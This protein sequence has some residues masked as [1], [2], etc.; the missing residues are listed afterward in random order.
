[1]PTKNG[2]RR[3]ILDA[4]EI[5]F[6]EKGYFNASVDRIAER[7][8]VA[9][10]TVYYNFAGKGAVFLA[11]VDRGLTELTRRVRLEAE[12]EGSARERLSRVFRAHAEMLFEYPR[13]AEIL[14]REMTSGLEPDVLDGIRAMRSAYLESLVGLVLDGRHE[15]VLAPTHPRLAAIAVTELS[16]AVCAELIATG[17]TRD[18][19]VEFLVHVF[20][21][22][23]LG[24]HDE[25]GN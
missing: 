18:E 4:G 25:P 19:A 20:T 23:L 17:G 5:E 11:V 6:A 2:T 1:M 12:R 22:G 16:Y 21:G 10:G 7:A 13:I 9:K 3:R 14:F 24:G 8:A 15:G